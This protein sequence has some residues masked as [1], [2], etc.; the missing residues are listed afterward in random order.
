[1]V[2]PWTRSTRGQPT[3]RDLHSTAGLKPTGNQ[4]RRMLPFGSPKREG[5]HDQTRRNAG[6]DTYFRLIHP[7]AEPMPA[8]PERDAGGDQSPP[9]VREYMAGTTKPVSIP[10]P[11]A[12]CEAVERVPRFARGGAPPPHWRR[13]PKQDGHVGQHRT[14]RTLRTFPTA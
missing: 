13:P 8:P 3:P 4:F 1:M 10:P 6:G 12:L 9:R 5:Q 2:V 11:T 7:T 14:P